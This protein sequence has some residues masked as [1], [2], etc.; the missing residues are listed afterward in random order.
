[1]NIA[2]IYQP[3]FKSE[4]FRVASKDQQGPENNYI[5]VTCSPQYNGIYKYPAKNIQDKHYDTWCNN[6]TLCICVPIKDCEKIKEL[7]QI[8][9]EDIIRDVRK[10][11]QDWYKSEVKNR[12]Y[13]YVNKPEWMI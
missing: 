1:M 12:D 11:Q 7:P 8:T 9:N 2:Y 6:K 4:C 3:H 13:N 10:Q 5:V